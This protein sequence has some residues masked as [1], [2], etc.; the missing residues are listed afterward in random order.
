[1]HDKGRG[2]I[3]MKIIGNG[4]FTDATDRE[5]SVRFAMQCGF[6]DAIVV[7][8]KS[9]AEVEEATRQKLAELAATLDLYQ[10]EPG[11]NGPWRELMM[12]DIGRE[13]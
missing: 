9:V 12:S 3:A 4:D 11:V 5:K 2:V 7:G 6:V 13:K 1:M 10:K 8:M